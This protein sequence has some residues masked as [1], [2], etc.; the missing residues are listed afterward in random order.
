MGYRA[1][2]RRLEPTDAVVD[3]LRRADVELVAHLPCGQARPLFRRLDATFRTVRLTREEEGVG[4]L[5]GAAMTGTRGAL[6][7]QS[8]GL[9]NALNALTTL[10]EA[11]ELPLPV[12]VSHRGRADDWNPAQVPQGRRTR[13]WLKSLDVP[14]WEPGPDGIRDAVRDA[15]HEAYD[16][17]RITAV[18]LAPTL[19][20]GGDGA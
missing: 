17:D 13:R 11:Y 2:P 15:V 5:A 6:V 16:A 4:I 20:D 9:G 18:L 8:S 19:F 14:P 10:T 1:S 12:I 3:G 7:M